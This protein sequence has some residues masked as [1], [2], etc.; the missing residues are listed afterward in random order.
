VA[1]GYAPRT[2]L[3]GMRGVLAIAFGL[4]PLTAIMLV[5]AAIMLSL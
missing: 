3:A 5:T 1:S 2:L 4:W